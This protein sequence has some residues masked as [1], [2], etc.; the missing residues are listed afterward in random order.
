MSLSDLLSDWTPSPEVGQGLVFLAVLYFLAVGPLRNQVAPGEPFPS[1]QVGWF[2]ASLAVLY[3]AVGSPLDAIAERYLFSLHMVQHNLLMW[4]FPPL[5]M[6]GLPPW[7]LRPFLEFA[8]VR[9][10]MRTFTRP[11]VALAL[12]T[13][14]FL[15]WHIPALYELTLRDRSVHFLE[16]ALIIGTSLLFWWPILSPLPEIPRIH[17]GQQMLY[18]VASMIAQTPVFFYLTFV[19]SVHY[20]TYANAIRIVNLTPLEDQQLGGILMK[21]VGGLVAFSIFAQAFWAWYRKEAGPRWK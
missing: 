11:V 14:V 7:L 1:R 21:V 16:H 9:W 18:A 15:V 13:L 8:P 3:L 10:A 12:F 20:P 17:Y 6:R 2:V 4:T 5:F 19:G